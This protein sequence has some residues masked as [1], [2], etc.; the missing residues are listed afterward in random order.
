MIDENT[1][2]REFLQLLGT[3]SI[4]NQLHENIWVNALF[5]DYDKHKH[6]NWIITDCRFPNEAKAVKDRGGIIVRVNRNDPNIGVYPDKFPL[7]R[8][9]HNSETALDD[10]TFDYTIDNSGTVDELVEKVKEMLK[11]FKL[12]NDKN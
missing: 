8:V 4:R 7:E 10:Y 5:A 9:L 11:H 12:Y 1:T 3:E 6:I 2:I